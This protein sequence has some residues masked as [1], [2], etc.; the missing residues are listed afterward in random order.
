VPF[1]PGA[2]FAVAGRRVTSW[3]WLAAAGFAFGLVAA[4]ISLA[5]SKGAELP[6]FGAP[7]AMLT[8]AIGAWLADKV[9]TAPAV[10]GA[11]DLYLRA[12]TP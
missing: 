6:L 1:V 11:L 3:R 12:S 10:A 5:I 4:I 7:V 8:F 9:W 2:I